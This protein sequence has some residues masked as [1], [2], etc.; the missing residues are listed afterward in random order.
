VKQKRKK[1]MSGIKI[2]GNKHLYRDPHSKALI[3]T[4][5]RAADEHR[6][7]QQIIE[8]QREEIDGLK[9]ELS[10]IKEMLKVLVKKYES[11]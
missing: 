9:S 1:K 2:Q 10:D 4:D 3:S 7:K 5:V 6:L 8:K 11:Q